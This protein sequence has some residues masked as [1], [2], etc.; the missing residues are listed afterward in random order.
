MRPKEDPAVQAPSCSRVGE[1]G[2]PWSPWCCPSGGT[3]VFS[4]VPSTDGICVFD[5]VSVIFNTK[6]KKIPGL[7]GIKFE[8]WVAPPRGRGGRL[9]PSPSWNVI[10]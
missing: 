6:R 5:I 10:E 1:V 8:G 4:A 9:F 7:C 2:G 3:Q